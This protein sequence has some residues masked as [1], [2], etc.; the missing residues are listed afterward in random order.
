MKFCLLYYGKLY[1]AW[2][3]MSDKAIK[4]LL[5]HSFWDVTNLYEQNKNNKHIEKYSKNDFT[6][7]TFNKFQI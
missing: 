7:F 4:H 1:I 2:Y 3:L 6:S 5:F